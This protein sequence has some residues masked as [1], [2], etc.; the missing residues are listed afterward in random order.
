MNTN[1]ESIA[2]AMFPQISETEEPAQW[3]CFVYVPLKPQAYMM[4]MNCQRAY[5]L[6]PERDME[7]QDWKNIQ[8]YAQEMI[9]EIERDI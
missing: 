3:Y 8:R 9:D 5:P 6:E 1:D 7:L 4:S 2:K